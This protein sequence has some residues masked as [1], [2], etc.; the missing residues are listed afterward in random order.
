MIDAAHIEP[1][2][3]GPCSNPVLFGVASALAELFPVEHL[4][5]AF[6]SAVPMEAAV[7]ESP[8]NDPL[9]AGGGLIAA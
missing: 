5:T 4:P 7:I 3:S 2:E 1:H 6:C 9:S 8:A